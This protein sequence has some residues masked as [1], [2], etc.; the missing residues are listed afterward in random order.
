[1]FAGTFD[2]TAAEAVCSGRG[3]ERRDVLDLLATLVEASMVDIGATD[4]TVRY[5]LLETVRHYAAEHLDDREAAAVRLAHAHTT[6]RS[7]DW[8]TPDS[9]VPTRPGGS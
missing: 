7:Q 2:L 1:M 4:G 5:S 9:A 8:P 6:P 3:I